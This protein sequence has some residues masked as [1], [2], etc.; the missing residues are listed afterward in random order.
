MLTKPLDGV[1]GWHSCVLLNELLTNLFPV[2]VVI[3]PGNFSFCMACFVPCRDSLG[4]SSLHAFL[5]EAAAQR[6]LCSNLALLILTVLMI[7]VLERVV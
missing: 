1:A 4:A 2:A 5:V 7:I 6:I 3:I